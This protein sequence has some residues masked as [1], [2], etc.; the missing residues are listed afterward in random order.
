M[1]EIWSKAI[2]ERL[3]CALRK[4]NGD[5]TLHRKTWNAL[6]AKA[7]ILSWAFTTLRCDY[8]SFMTITGKAL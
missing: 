4:A 6:N 2:Y 5:K 3:E 8:E 1:N 7:R